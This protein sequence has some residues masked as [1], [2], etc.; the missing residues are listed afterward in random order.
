MTKAAALYQFFS[1]F[2]MPAYTSTSVPEDAIFPY[3]TYEL[4]TST[5]EA[6]EVSLTV[7]L[8]FYTESEKI[9]NTKADE[10][11]RAIGLGGK[12]LPCD[13]GYIWLKRGSPWC[14]SLSDETS[15]TIKRRYINVT[16]EYLT[17][18]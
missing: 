10:I 8:W 15:P 13:G 17:E 2:D 14:Q 12:I 11:S 3:L 6:G 7:N 1:S 4:I 5:W 18:N 16:A 9:P